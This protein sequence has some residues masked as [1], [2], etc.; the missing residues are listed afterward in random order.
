MAT[1]HYKGSADF[2][3][4]PADA[5]ETVHT[6]AIPLLISPRSGFL[7][8]SRSQR[9]ESWNADM[10]QREVFTIGDPVYEIEAVIRMDNQ[11]AL[12]QSMMEY[13]LNEDVTIRYRPDGATEYPLKVLNAG[14]E[15]GRIVIT[16]D[17]ERFAF[18]EWQCR[19][20]AR[21][22]DGSDFSGLF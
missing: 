16:P 1:A 2:I 9:F 14:G 20:R 6:L 5:S 15:N 8:E 18:G 19:F 21:R 3:Y 13:A 22:V 10:T 4:D 7:N 12:I 17:T 11:P